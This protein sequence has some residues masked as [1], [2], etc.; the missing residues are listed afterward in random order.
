[1][2][3]DMAMENFSKVFHI[4]N[5]T[6]LSDTSTILESNEMNTNPEVFLVT[7]FSCSNIMLLEWFR[8]F[9]CIT[10]S[11]RSKFL[12]FLCQQGSVQQSHF[13]HPLFQSQTKNKTFVTLEIFMDLFTGSKENVHSRRM[14][15]FPGIV[16][17]SIAKFL[18]S[19][20]SS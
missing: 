9:R 15:I 12:F 5:L 18:I 16:S 6:W 11:S 1:M 2:S 3:L 19:I 7:S 4:S 13:L 20:R 14:M 8:T 17:N 10:N